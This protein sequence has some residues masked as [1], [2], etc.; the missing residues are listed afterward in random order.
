M[1]QLIDILVICTGNICRSPMG[2]GLLARGLAE[3]GHDVRVSSAGTHATLG[4]VDTHVRDLME[5]AGLDVSS[6]RSRQ[7][8]R[9]MLVEADLVIGMD[10]GHVR[11]VVMLEPSILERT[12]TLKELV[13]RGEAVGGRRPGEPFDVWLKRVGEGRE[14]SELLGSD[15]RDDIADPYGRRSSHYRRAAEE[16]AALTSELVRLVGRPADGAP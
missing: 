5:G 12:F 2:E 8:E 15:P 16:I 13:R 7:V 1:I 14:P 11:H 4:A 3:A 9:D 6:H 10:R